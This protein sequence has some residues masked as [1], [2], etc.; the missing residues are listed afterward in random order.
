MFGIQ[1]QLP[2]GAT[3][4]M[5]EEP[6]AVRS[7]MHSAGVVDANTAAQSGVG[8]ARAHF[9]KQ[10]PSN[11]RKSN[12]FHFVLA[13]YDRQGQPVEIE[14][15][16]YVDFVEKEK[17]PTGEKTNNGIH[18]KLQLLYSNGVR[19]EQDLYVRLIDSM[20]KQPIIYEGQ[21]KNPE[22]CRVLL[23]HEIMC[24]RCC[25]KKSCG[26]RNE[27]PSDPVI[28]DRFFL[29]FFLKCNQNCLKNAGN[30]RDMRR[31]QV[32]VSTTVNVDGHVLAV[33]D[34][35]FVHNNSKH[36]R[37]A[38]RLDPSEGKQDFFYTATPCIKAI[39]PS[40]GWTTGGATVI[41]IGDNFFDG[42]QVVF[43]TML[44]WSELITPHAIRVQTPP[45]H[46]PGVVEVTLSYKSKQFCKGAPGRFVYTAL[47]EPTID[48]GFQRLQKVIPRHP[49]DPER[50][51]KE[52][53]LK[54]AADLVEA[55]YGM[56][57][58]NQEI[59]L[60]RA[61]DIAEALYSV[62]RNHNQIPSLGNT[63]SHGM[64]GVNSF[65][66]QLAVNVSDATQVGYSR[67]TSSVSPRGYVP[68]S[69]PQQSNYG[70]TVSNS[71]N[72]YGNTGMPNLGVATS[73]GFLNGS[74]TNSPYGIVP[75]SPT[76]AVSNCNS[77]HGVFSFSAAVKQK[78]A[79]AP[80]VRPSASPPPPPNCSG[81]NSNGLQ[82]MSGL[83]VPP[84]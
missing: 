69:T 42:L 62:P 4:S 78:S 18:Y 59:I 57:H 48:Y 61:A 45:R 53:L 11:L 83:V 7:W 70:N 21:D 55:L 56:P 77:S 58:N 40:E 82:A 12:F 49:G 24:S 25:D 14:R 3:A 26:N 80:V 31:F 65:S 39:S 34:N 36:G 30:P 76:M 33:S 84:M 44:V 63:T 51:P 9:E 43:G 46:I 38:R 35:M 5:K 19:T 15:T 50:L 20:T 47:N 81:N 17:E 68:S 37:R 29:K 52:V 13:L 10:P 60:K 74:S 64:M 67:N 16:T 32:V 27:T 2:R 72:G 73:P 6:L 66:G 22:M 75:S 71:M 41:L 54:R 28:I 8:L 23:T 1:D 79:F